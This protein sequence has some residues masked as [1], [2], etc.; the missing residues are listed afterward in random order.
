[1]SSRTGTR[2]GGESE[3]SLGLCASGNSSGGTGAR[4]CSACCCRAAAGASR[5]SDAG[6]GCSEG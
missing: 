1:M 2:C 5:L 4:P 6:G 3:R